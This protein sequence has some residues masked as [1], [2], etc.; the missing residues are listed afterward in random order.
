[1]TSARHSGVRSATSLTLPLRPS[2]AR[3]KTQLL[4]QRPIAG[5]GNI[6]ADEALWLS[7]L[8]PLRTV[9]TLRPPDERR[10]Y[11]AIRSI[12][13]AIKNP[14][15]HTVYVG[16]PVSVL[17]INE[18]YAGEMI[19]GHTSVDSVLQ[20]DDRTRHVIHHAHCRVFLA[21]TPVISTKVM[22]KKICAG[23]R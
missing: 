9:A 23:S 4:S 14:L 22:A 16:F 3:V 10:L 21:T 6:Y 1:M 20:I 18:R 17:A 11:Q 19:T 12:L 8:H 7:R 15:S 2:R 5:V 13:A